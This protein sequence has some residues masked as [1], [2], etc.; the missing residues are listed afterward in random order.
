[1]FKVN[2]YIISKRETTIKERFKNIS[3]IKM[4]YSY[5]VHCNFRPSYKSQT[6][7]SIF[8]NKNVFRPTISGYESYRK[9]VINTEMQT[10]RI[11]SID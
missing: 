4:F 9:M 7:H 6:L 5:N 11:R 10:T 8:T 1:M 3:Q 2:A